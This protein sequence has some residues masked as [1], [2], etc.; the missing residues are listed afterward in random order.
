VLRFLLEH[1]KM[2]KMTVQMITASHVTIVL[3]SSTGAAFSLMR[4]VCSLLR[5]IAF[6]AIV[7]VLFLGMTTLYLINSPCDTTILC[8]QSKLVAALSFGVSYQ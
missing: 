7:N 3:K 5:R 2:T 4:I 6:A 1:D 8:L